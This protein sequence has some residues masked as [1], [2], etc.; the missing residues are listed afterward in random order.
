MMYHAKKKFTLI[1]LLVVI[2]IIAILAGMLL[3]ALN[4]ARESARTANC[5][6]NL[7]Q[8]GLG[9]N[10]YA[11]DHNGLLSPNKASGFTYDKTT[12]AGNVHYPGLLLPYIPKNTWTC[13][14][15]TAY[16]EVIVAGV[17]DDFSKNWK[18]GYGINQTCTSTTTNAQRLDYGQC[19]IASIQNPGGTILFADN[20]AE[21]NTD[22]WIGVYKKIDSYKPEDI[23]PAGTGNETT[24]IA[25][26][27]NYPHGG[28]ANFL[29]ADG[30][31]E[32]R[33]EKA[34]TAREWCRYEKW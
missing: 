23:V 22:C 2:A 6:S 34:V 30:H 20:V 10:F 24:R 16:F 26:T 3:P 18:V 29:W 15:M 7:K 25:T 19:A 31:V 21:N 8:I 12:Y 28:S 11:D 33:A 32:K 27:G 17:D 4:K 9:V 5:V 14:S 13:P 1:E